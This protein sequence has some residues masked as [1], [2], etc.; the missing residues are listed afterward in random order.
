MPR[1]L[2]TAQRELD[3]ARAVLA[4][5]EE[6]VRDGGDVTPKQLADQR[7]LIAF[8]E[9]RVE[10]AQ[11]TETRLR[12]EERAALADSA[13]QAAVQLIDGPGMDAIAAATA[14]AVD[15][16]TSLAALVYERNERIAEVGQTLTQLD[17]DMRANGAAEG[18]WGT[19]RYGVWGDHSRVAVPGT[20]AADRLDA[21][22]LTTAVVVAGL[23]ESP[24]GREAQTR[25]MH[26]FNGMRAQMIANLVEAHPQLAEALGVRQGVPA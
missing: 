6:Q 20:G 17:Q 14:T 8:A 15:A 3:D 25:H 9:L 13:R 24:Q 5:L 22:R 18:P 4:A 26:E 16:L 19:R 1:D 12:E 2:K 11:R 21:G 7:E 10:A 23:G